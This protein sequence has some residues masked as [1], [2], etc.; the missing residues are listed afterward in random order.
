MFTIAVV[1]AYKISRHTS[2]SYKRY[3][4]NCEVMQY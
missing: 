1:Y 2:G 4:Q 3:I